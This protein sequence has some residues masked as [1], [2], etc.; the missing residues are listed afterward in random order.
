M[1]ITSLEGFLLTPWLTG[2]ASRMNAVAVFIGVLFWGWLWGIWG[3]LLSV[4]ITVMVKV[5]AQHVEQL[6]TIS[7]LLGD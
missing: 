4:P 6:E 3:L 7:E 5:V 1:L 2:R